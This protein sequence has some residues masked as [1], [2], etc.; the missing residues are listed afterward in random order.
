MEYFTRKPDNLKMPKSVSDIVVYKTK[1]QKLQEI[2]NLFKQI[3]IISL[4]KKVPKLIEIMGELEEMKDKI[5]N[6]PLTKRQQREIIKQR[7]DK[8]KAL[9][10]ASEIADNAYM[11][12]MREDT[13]SSKK[14]KKKKKKH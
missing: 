3:M 14:S 12:L 4:Q 10:L 11:E 13:I 2:D 5:N 9:K 8:K 7:R 6:P 1:E